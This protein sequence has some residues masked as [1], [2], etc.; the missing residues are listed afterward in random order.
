MTGKPSLKDILL[1]DTK[2]AKVPEGPAQD[3]L[4]PGDY[5]AKVISFTE[6]DTYQYMVLEMNKEKYNFIYRYYI[7]D[8]TFGNYNTLL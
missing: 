1:E 4:P 8:T 5:R 2:N 6:E 7:K 3:V